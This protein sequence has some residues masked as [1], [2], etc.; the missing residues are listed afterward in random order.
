MRDLAEE[1]K[2][3]L[4]LRLEP[5]RVEGVAGAREIGEHVAEILPDQLAAA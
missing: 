4:A 5:D 1:R 2:A 3:E